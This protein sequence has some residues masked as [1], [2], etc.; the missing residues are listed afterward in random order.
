M[1]HCLKGIAASLFSHSDLL[2]RL[3]FSTIPFPGKE[4]GWKQQL[5][6][7]LVADVLTLLMIALP[8]HWQVFARLCTVLIGM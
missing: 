6:L 2:G 5:L 7:L 4:N 8:H 3:W 1:I